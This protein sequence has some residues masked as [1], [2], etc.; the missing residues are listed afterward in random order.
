[1]TAISFGICHGYDVSGRKTVSTSVPA[2]IADASQ[3]MVR[4]SLS[5]PDAAAKAAS[6]YQI[7]ETS[8]ESRMSLSLVRRQARPETA[9]EP[10]RRPERGPDQPLR[11]EPSQLPTGS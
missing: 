3:R 7:T 2:S 6:H 1:M 9:L 11:C 5:T 8:P 10:R 4:V